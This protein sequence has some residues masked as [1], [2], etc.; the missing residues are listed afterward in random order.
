MHGGAMRYTLEV[1]IDG[2][3]VQVLVT[4]DRAEVIGFIF[5]NNIPDEDICLTY[6]SEVK[7]A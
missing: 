4:N 3:L 1:E 6:N 5:D 7:C 2:I